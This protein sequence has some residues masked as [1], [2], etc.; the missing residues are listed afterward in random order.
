MPDVKLIPLRPS[1]RNRF[2]PDRQKAFSYGVPEEFGPR[3]D[4]F[5]EEGDIISRRTIEQSIDSGEAC[6]LMPDVHPAGG[7][8]IR[9]DGDC[10]DLEFLFVSPHVHSKGIG[11]AAW[12]AGETPHSEVKVWETV[13]LCFETRNI[14]FCVNRALPYCGILQQ[15]SPG[16]E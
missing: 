1:D 2:I 5:E 14:L 9:V 16:P 7:V 10:G 15:P 12:C 4:H 8:I 3:K 11:Y 13:T 6:R